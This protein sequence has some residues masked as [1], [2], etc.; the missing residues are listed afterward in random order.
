MF[1]T[2]ELVPGHGLLVFL[3]KR[4]HDDPRVKRIKQIVLWIIT[5]YSTIIGLV[6]IIKDVSLYIGHKINYST[7]PIY[8]LHYLALCVWSIVFQLLL[9]KVANT[10]F[11]FK[12]CWWNLHKKTC[13]FCMQYL[14]TS[15]TPLWQNIQNKFK[16]LTLKS[17]ET[18]L[19]K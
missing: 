3:M 10:Y 2:C 1:D 12:S 13:E 18:L 17:K 14:Q 15:L 19:L 16:N 11:D 8:N 9:V 6:K 4:R 5:G 7:I